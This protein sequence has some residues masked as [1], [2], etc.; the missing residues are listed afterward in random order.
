MDSDMDELMPLNS[1]MEKEYLSLEELCQ[2]IP[3]RPQTVRNLMSQGV[4]RQGVHYFKP[5]SRRIVFKWEAVRAWIEGNDR[6]ERLMIPL[7]RGG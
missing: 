4:L 7:A 5:T 1:A 3:Y 6:K 2:R